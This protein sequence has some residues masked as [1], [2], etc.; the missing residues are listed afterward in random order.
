MDNSSAPSVL[1]KTEFIEE[2]NSGPRDPK[3]NRHLSVSETRICEA[4]ITFWFS[5]M[6]NCDTLSCNRTDSF[7]KSSEFSAGGETDFAEAPIVTGPVAF[8]FRLD[9]GFHSLLG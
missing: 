9:F 5:D 8:G 4:I 1:V 3:V 6:F 7:C 2:L